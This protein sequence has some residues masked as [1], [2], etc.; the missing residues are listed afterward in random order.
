MLKGGEHTE[1]S[2]GLMMSRRGQRK[3]ELLDSETTV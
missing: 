1:G 2:D 3:D